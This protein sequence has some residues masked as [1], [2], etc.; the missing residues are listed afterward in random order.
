MLYFL[1]KAGK[2]EHE[3]RLSLGSPILGHRGLILYAGL[4]P[5]RNKL[6]VTPFETN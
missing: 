5:D 2:R 3:G 1:T 4:S 6:V